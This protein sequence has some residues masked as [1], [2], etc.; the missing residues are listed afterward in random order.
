M[1]TAWPVLRGTAVLRVQA[2]NGPWRGSVSG[3]NFAPLAS[4]CRR[5]APVFSLC[6]VA[7]RLPHEAPCR[8][9]AL[10]NE[11]GMS[12]VYPRPSFVFHHVKSRF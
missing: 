11:P 5:S 9:S 4:A 10:P 6:Q 12:A 8:P 1:D 3:T 2:K 7:A